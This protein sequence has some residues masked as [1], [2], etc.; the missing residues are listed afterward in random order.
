MNICCGKNYKHIHLCDLVALI[1][2]L[3]LFYPLNLFGPER[4]KICL[5]DLPTTK[6]TD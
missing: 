5:C 3:M 4:K 2:T 6:S 1:H